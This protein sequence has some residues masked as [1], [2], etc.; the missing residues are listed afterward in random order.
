[1]RLLAFVRALRRLDKVDA[2]NNAKLFI[3]NSVVDKNTVP[4]PAYHLH[5]SEIWT[6]KNITVWDNLCS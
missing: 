5:V 6:V 1:M 4:M 2:R 3:P